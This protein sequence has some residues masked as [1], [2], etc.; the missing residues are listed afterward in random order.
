MHEVA[1]LRDLLIWHLQSLHDAELQWAAALEETAALVTAADLKHT[2]HTG[3]VCATRHAATIR[4]ILQQLEAS[5]LTNRNAVAHDLVEEFRSL[6]NIAADREVLDAALVVTHQCM[7]HYRMAKYGAAASFARL[8]QQYGIAEQLRNML[9]EEKSE[10]RTLT[11]LA[12]ETL[13]S[14]ART[15]IV[16]NTGWAG[17]IA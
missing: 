3:N 12:E 13:N 14:R 15:V 17:S 6:K 8:L 9:E 7:N 4:D 10:D 16:E 1:L 5:S 2:F 11:K